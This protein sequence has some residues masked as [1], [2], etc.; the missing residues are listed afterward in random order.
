MSEGHLTCHL[1]T[2][3]SFPKK[4]DLLFHLTF[5]HFSKDLLHLHPYEE[6][7]EC[8]LCEDDPV[9]ATSMSSHLRHTGVGHGEVL[10]FLTPDVAEQIREEEPKS[11]PSTEPNET[12]ANEPET[13]KITEPNDR[14]IHIHSL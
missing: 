1:C 3:R 13:K 11:S 2:M 8:S 12:V 6:N 7:K 5:S 9:A 10:Q 14:M 4:D